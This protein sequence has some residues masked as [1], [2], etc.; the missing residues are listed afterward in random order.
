ML[1]VMKSF[2][3]A[4][5]LMLFGT[6]ANA[7]ALG[8]AD[9]VGLINDGIPSSPAA[10]V[11]YINNLITLAPGT[12]DTVIGTETYNRISSTLVGPLPVAEL[13]GAIKD[14]SE[15]VVSLD[16]TGFEYVLAK[17]DAAQAGSLVW[18]MEGGFSGVV[19]PQATLNGLGLSHISAYNATTRVPEPTS[20]T[21]LGG[22]LIALAFIGRRRR[23]WS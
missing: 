6:A 17:Y 3:L 11:G 7:L 12:G 19:T 13:A 2:G 16:A 14:E 22:C 15:G 20:L 5:V 9:Y 10:E 21:L 18:Y 8:D 4:A 23:I 1:R